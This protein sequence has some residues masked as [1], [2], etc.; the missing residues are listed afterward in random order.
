MRVV[1]AGG[2]DGGRWGE[3]ELSALDAP[4]HGTT[5]VRE[6]RIFGNAHASLSKRYVEVGEKQLKRVRPGQPAVRV[7][8][9]WT[10]STEDVNA[11]L[12]RHGCEWHGGGVGTTITGPVDV[13][14]LAEAS[15]RVASCCREVVGLAR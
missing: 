4:V 15:V 9:G 13:A 14:S 11:V 12:E 5:V 2:Y 10:W 6:E 8:R 3:I 7:V 1:V